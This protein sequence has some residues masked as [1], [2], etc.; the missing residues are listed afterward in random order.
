[1]TVL[2]VFSCG[3]DIDH[4]PFVLHLTLATNRAMRWVWPP[5]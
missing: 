1:M 5:W 3:W 4:P 2:L